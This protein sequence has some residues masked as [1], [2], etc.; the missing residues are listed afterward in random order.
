MAKLFVTAVAEWLKNQPYIL[1][2]VE[3]QTGRPGG[4]LP[5]ESFAVGLLG[6]VAAETS[7][8][9]IRIDQLND[10]GFQHGFY[11]LRLKPP[12]SFT[13]WQSSM[14]NFV[15]TVEVRNGQDRGQC[16]AINKCCGDAGIDQKSLRSLKKGRVTTK[17][18]TS[19][20]KNAK[21]KRT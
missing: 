6:A 11:T 2:S 7:W 15:F 14:S 4:E 1:V 3:T 17:G 12:T 16:L 8:R 13:S 9:R 21:S 20:P 19:K 10:T 18:S 5:F